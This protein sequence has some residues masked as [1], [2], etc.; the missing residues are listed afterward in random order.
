[1]TFH[2]PVHPVR[3]EIARPPAGARRQA[4]LVGRVSDRQPARTGRGHQP[5]AGDYDIMGVDFA[6]RGKR[7]DEC[8]DIIAG[9]T[10][11]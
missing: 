9:L 10:T 2:D 5:V 4:G 11:F 3:A 7:M 6:R 8:M 1:M